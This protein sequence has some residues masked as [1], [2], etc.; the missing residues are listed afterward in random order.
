[1]YA[2]VADSGRASDLG[3]ETRAKRP[4]AGNSPNDIKL[5]ANGLFS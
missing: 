1:M 3:D 2:F 5:S 4:A